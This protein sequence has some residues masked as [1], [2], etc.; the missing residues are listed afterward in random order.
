MLVG[1]GVA[2][3]SGLLP[4][5]FV[6]GDIVELGFLELGF[7]FGTVLGVLDGVFGAALGVGLGVLGVTSG[8]APGSVCMV[9]ELGLVGAAPG[10]FDGLEF[11]GVVVCGHGAL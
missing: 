5:L 1:G 6:D 11:P 10:V 7:E 3:V 9:E 8:T 4:G 2:F